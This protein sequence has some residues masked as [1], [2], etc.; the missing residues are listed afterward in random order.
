MS[1]SEQNWWEIKSAK[2]ALF[3]CSQG[4]KSSTVFD[5]RKGTAKSKALKFLPKTLFN[6]NSLKRL[7]V[8]NVS[9]LSS[10]LIPEPHYVWRYESPTARS[11]LIL[12]CTCI[13]QLL[14]VITVS[15]QREANIVVQLYPWYKFLYFPCVCSGV[16]QI[17]YMINECK[18]KE[19]TRLYQ[20]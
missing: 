11:L 9:I 1:I 7:A 15:S 18:T 2:L 13:S 6:M 4:S 12:K 16:R 8:R 19:N 17:I 10:T 5:P 20:R 14:F 3:I